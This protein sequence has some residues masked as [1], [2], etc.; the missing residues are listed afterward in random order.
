M[1]ARA[2]LTTVTWPW[3]QLSWIGKASALFLRD[4]ATP[5]HHLRIE[6]RILRFCRSAPM[7]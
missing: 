3:R 7:L 2:Y 5:S 1:P 4:D 6:K